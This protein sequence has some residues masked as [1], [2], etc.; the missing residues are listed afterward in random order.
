VT[1]LAASCCATALPAAADATDATLTVIVDQDVN[2]NGTYD[3]DIDVPQGGIEIDVRDAGGH[4]V[5]GVTDENGEFKLPATDQLSGGRYFVVAVIPAVLAYLSPVPESSSFAPLS[6]AVDV[7]SDA[8]TVRMGVVSSASPSQ[9]APSPQTSTTEAPRDSAVR[10]AIGDFVWHD[11]DRSGR[12]DP[13]EPPAARVGVQLLDANGDVVASTVTSQTGRY[14]FDRLAAGTYSVRFAGIPSGYRITSAAAGPDRS[15]DSDPDYGGSTPSIFLGV[16]EPNVRPAAPAD[17][18]SAAY[19]N[20]TVDAGITG[21]RYAVGDHVWFDAN[22]DGIRQPGEAPAAATV[23]LLAGNTVLATTSTDPTGRFLFS[24]LEAGRYRVRFSGL[25]DHRALTHKAVGVDSAPDPVTGI[26]PS[27]TLDP[28]A[29]N[30]VPA[31]DLG[32]TTADF[33]NPTL[34]AGLVGSYSVGDTVWRDSDG[35]GLLGPGEVGVKGVRVDLLD[36]NGQVLGSA[37][38]SGSGRYTFDGLSAG[39]YRIR[40]GALPPGLRLTRQHSGSNPAVDS[41]PD[42]SGVTAP[43]TLGDEDPADTTVDA[44]VTT[45]ADY[46][47]APVAGAGGTPVDSSL[48]STGGLSPIVPFGG[49]ALIGGGLACVMVSRR[50][51]H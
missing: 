13:G 34:N 49:L 41:D 14:I 35:D 30:L 17:H 1:I 32:V 20:P 9:S 25:P 11:T 22:A 23:S 26:T 39:T 45:P 18:V 51:R 29:P 46:A 36:P 4:E 16:G 7:S 3:H 21:L 6:T 2:G 19:I 48:S 33:V 31:T 43:I 44:G 27:F 40:F 15:L 38:T 5:K 42:S 28:G 37:R 12:Q 24:D 10:F 8:Q 47:A 50:R